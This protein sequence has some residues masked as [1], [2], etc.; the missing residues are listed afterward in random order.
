[1][2]ETGLFGRELELGSAAERVD[3]PIV[4]YCGASVATAESFG[5][6]AF[7]AVFL[8][9]KEHKGVAAE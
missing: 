3:T 4:E 6:H 5:I 8:A 9:L 2:G 7:L 1:M